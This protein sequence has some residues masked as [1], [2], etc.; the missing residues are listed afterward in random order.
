M[1]DWD[2][3]FGYRVFGDEV[4]GTE[5]EQHLRAECRTRIEKALDILSSRYPDEMGFSVYVYVSI[6]LSA[7]TCPEWTKFDIGAPLTYM[8]TDLLV[9]MLD[10]AMTS[11][12]HEDEEDPGILPPECLSWIHNHMWA[13]IYREGFKFG[14]LGKMEPNLVKAFR[15]LK[16]TG[17]L[18]D[19]PPNTMLVHDSYG[20]NVLKRKVWIPGCL[21]DL[22]LANDTSVPDIMKV[23][24]KQCFLDHIVDHAVYGEDIDA[25]WDVLEGEMMDYATAVADGE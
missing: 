3:I 4:A 9:K 17:L 7:Y 13:H 25:P 18:D 23:L 24:Y 15:K 1:G 20:A 5:E 8:P 19:M 11:A 21:K 10:S 6:S 2:V 16:E 22:G 14:G 12:A